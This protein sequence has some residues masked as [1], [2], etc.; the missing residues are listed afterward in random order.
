M[1]LKWAIKSFTRAEN[2]NSHLKV[3][4]HSR[5]DLDSLGILKGFHLHGA[6]VLEANIMDSACFFYK[7]SR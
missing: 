4:K 2:A 1:L 5:K 3:K 6:Q 7:G